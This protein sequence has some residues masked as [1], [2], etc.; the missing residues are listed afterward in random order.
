MIV[1]PY[2]DRYLVRT[3]EGT[4]LL[5][6]TLGVIGAQVRDGPDVRRIWTVQGLYAPIPGRAL[7]GIRAR[8]IDT[9][10]FVSFCN[11]RDLEV[12]LGAGEPGH[13][14]QWLGKEYVDEWDPEWIGICADDDDLLDDLYDRELLLRAESV[15]D[16]L[17]TGMELRRFYQR[18]HKRDIDEVLQLI[19]DAEP[20]TGM[21][22][23]PR[24]ETVGMRWGILEQRKSNAWPLVY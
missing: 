24:F 11:Q 6:E 12:L 13:Y 3:F 4:R 20:E 16:M 23:D 15:T 5:Q 10:G 18:E 21:G 2:T 7:G 1:N 9:K 19:L 14:C 22:P 8:L 17:E